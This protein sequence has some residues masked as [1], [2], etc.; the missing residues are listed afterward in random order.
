[1]GGG[2]SVAALRGGKAINVNSGLDEGPLTPERS[3]QLPMLQF[4]KLCFSGKYTEAELKKMLVGKGGFV[5]YFN[6]NNARDVEK[7]ALGGSERHKLV[8]EA[9]AYQ[10]AQEIGA[11]A[12]NLNGKVDGII[13]T[14]GVAHSKILTDWITERVKFISDVHIYKGELELE[15]LAAGGLRVLKGEEIPNHYSKKIKK[16]GII[17]WDNL[18]VYSKAVTVIE[19]QFVKNG[20]VFRK[21]S[22]NMTISY[23]N[24]EKDEDKVTKGIEKFKNDKVDII[25]AIGSPISMRL[26]Q[27]LKEEEIPVIFTGIYNSS[28]INDLIT[29]YFII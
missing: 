29:A 5:S 8:Y 28:I 1:M 20:F 2:I 17:Y 9:V 24:C 19:D 4:L 21:K 7:M 26:S 18:E 10:V 12:T 23:I 22:N 3:G 16:V 13:L 6:T 27:F 25:I 14:G 15:A 11:R